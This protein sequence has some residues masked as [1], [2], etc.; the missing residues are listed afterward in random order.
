VSYALIIARDA[1]PELKRL[2]F[3]LQEEAFDELEELAEDPPH[4]SGIR[5]Y[6]MIRLRDDTVEAVILHLWV[7]TA[8]ATI[9]LLGVDADIP[10]R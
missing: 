4:S 3:W 5:P 6:R 2:D 9:T 10:P 1:L 8:A 7:D